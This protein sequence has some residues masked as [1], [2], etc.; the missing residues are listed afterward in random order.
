MSKYSLRTIRNKAHKINYHVSKG[1]QKYHNGAIIRDC[2]GEPWEGYMVLDLET[3]SWVYDGFDSSCTYL[4][5]LEDVEDFLEDIY[6]EKGLV[7]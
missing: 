1:Y 7:Y 6:K 5:T 2:N 3:N 4:W